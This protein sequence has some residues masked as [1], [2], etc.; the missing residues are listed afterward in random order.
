MFPFQPVFAV[1]LSEMH[2]RSLL[3]EPLE[4]KIEITNTKEID[5]DG[6]IVI[7]AERDFYNQEGIEPLNWIYTIDLKTEKD[8]KTGKT[9]VRLT[10][11]DPIKDPFVDLIIMATWEGGKII[12]SYTLLL[13][14]PRV[15]VPKSLAPKAR[16][17]SAQTVKKTID[18]TE[19]ANQQNDLVA[20]RKMPGTIS[21]TVKQRSNKRHL[22]RATP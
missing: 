5:A 19:N 1:E 2:V 8:P 11:S 10:T 15:A 16:S 3:N 12:K 22:E 9:I 6:L 21:T 20:V 13:D 17:K 4:A 18:L 14:P 7:V